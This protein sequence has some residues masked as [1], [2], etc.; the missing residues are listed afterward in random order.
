MWWRQLDELSR[1][2]MRKL[3]AERRFVFVEGGWVQ[4]DEAN[5]SVDAIVDQLTEGHEFLRRTFGVGV[6]PRIAWQ[7]G[8][9]LFFFDFSLFLL[10]RF[11]L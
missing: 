11:F 10:I 4:H 2:A 5:P 7:I 3:V 1:N 6:R 9:I 8:N